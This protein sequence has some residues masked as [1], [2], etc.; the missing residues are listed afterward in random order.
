MRP[1]PVPSGSASR[2]H[3][4]QIR[5]A[6]NRSPIRQIRTTAAVFSIHPAARSRRNRAA[7]PHPPSFP[8]FIS[9]WEAST[10]FFFFSRPLDP[11]L[12]SGH[13]RLWILIE[14]ER[15]QRVPLL[16][17]ATQCRMVEQLDASE[18]SRPGSPRASCKTAAC[19]SSVES[20]QL[21]SL[22]VRNGGG[23]ICK[24]CLPLRGQKAVS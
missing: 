6:S 16:R 20:H 12:P 7:R 18:Q 14:T 24:Q 8:C 21:V 17:V 23:K 15:H 19:P 11:S 1:R 3:H 22:A 4:R 5:P 2:N 9:A 10:S 13:L